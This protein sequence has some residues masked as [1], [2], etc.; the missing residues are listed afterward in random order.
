MWLRTPPHELEVAMPRKLT[1]EDLVKE[2]ATKEMAERILKAQ[3]T[4]RPRTIWWQFQGSEEL[5]A[6]VAKQFPA[7]GASLKKRFMPRED[8][9]KPK[10]EGNKQ[11]AK[12]AAKP[13]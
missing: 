9:K 12:A 3:D 8:S 4:A 1:I 10:A 5:A 2:G 6:Q 11:P 7:V 13:K